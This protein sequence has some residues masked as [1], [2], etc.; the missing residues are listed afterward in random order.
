MIRRDKNIILALQIDT[1]MKKILCYAIILLFVGACKKDNTEG[2]SNPTPAPAAGELSLVGIKGSGQGELVN[3]DL[4][5]KLKKTFPLISGYVMGSIVFEPNTFS[6]GYTGTDH[7]FHLISMLTGKEIKTI[8]FPGE[9]AVSQTIV[10]TKTNTLISVQPRQEGLYILKNNLTN[11]TLIS[12]GKIDIPGFNSCT[13]FY[14]ETTNTFYLISSESKLVAIDADNGA[15]K[16]SV[17]VTMVNNAIFNKKN[18]TIIGITSS[19]E[20]NVIV[21]VDVAT[22]HEL[23]RKVIEETH[24]YYACAAE[25]EPISDS[26]INFTANKELLFIDPA[27]GKIRQKIALDVDLTQFLFWRK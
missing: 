16:S 26:Y 10:N 12:E 3:M 14:N 4:G 15:V 19:G 17:D 25:Y 22:G 11:G 13:Y 27:T 6:V 8:S 7:K 20:Q 9:G 21:T 24:A 5:T 1:I 23:S 2:N 18:N